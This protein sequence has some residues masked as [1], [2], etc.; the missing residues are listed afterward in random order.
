MVHIMSLFFGPLLGMLGLLLW[1]LFF[2]RQR[3]TDRLL[4]LGVFALAGVSAMILA[5]PTFGMFGLSIALRYIAAAWVVWL[6]VTPFLGWPVRRAGLLALLVLGWG[7]CDLVRREGVKG[8]METT[9]FYRWSPTDEDKFLEELASGK[10]VAKSAGA[11]KPLVLQA[12]DWPGFRGPNRDGRVTGVKIATN[13]EQNPPRLVW[14]HRVGPGWSSF[15]VV[16]N[17]LFTQEQR[18]EAQAVVCYD[19]DTGAQLWVYQEAGGYQ[20][21]MSGK[22]PRATPTFHD[23][24]LYTLDAS[25]R[26]TCLDALTGRKIW[27]KDIVAD[28]GATKPQWGFAS[29]PLV[30]QGIVTVFAG[31]PGKAVLGYKA[32]SGALAWAGGEGKECYGS[33]HPAKLGGVEQV[34]MASDA[35]LTAFEPASGKV[36]WKHDWPMGGN[37]CRV[38]QPAVLSETDVL[39]GSGFH[40]GTRLVRVGHDA[41]GRERWTE[42]EVWTSR[43]LSPYFNDAVVHAG[44][45][46][47]FDSTIFTCVGLDKGKGGWK[48]RGYGNGQVLLL[49]DQGLLLVV[50]EDEEKGEVVLVAATPDEHRELGRFT[51]LAGKTWNHPVVVNGRLYIRNSVEAACYQLD[52][53]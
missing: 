15:A 43:A 38:V 4:V 14:K 41:S 29:S 17:R 53:K 35:G 16:G 30:V 37:M 23:G 7:A 45:L 5:H 8:D 44:H 26:L 19:A 24:K 27:A 21:E 34:L 12:G 11:D 10:H 42:Q 18:G 33:P 6:A 52:G 46:Y 36:L 2:S 39:F 50:T 32:D 25:G 51:A 47:G 22:G 31:G 1:W 9:F 49:A 20:D 3:W 48:A 28:S 40:K 13:W